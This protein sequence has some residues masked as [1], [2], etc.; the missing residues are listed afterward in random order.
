MASPRC[1]LLADACRRLSRWQ[2]P[3]VPLRRRPPSRSRR[4]P[5]RCH[6]ILWRTRSSGCY[7]APAHSRKNKESTFGCL[8]STFPWKN[9]PGL[10]TGSFVHFWFWKPSHSGHHAAR[11]VFDCVWW[12]RCWIAGW[13]CCHCCFQSP[14]GCHL[15]LCTELCVCMWHWKSCCAWNR[16]NKWASTDAG[17][18]WRASAGWLSRWCSR[19]SAAFEFSLG[20]LFD[21]I[22][23]NVNVFRKRIT[24]K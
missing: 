16:F 24:R 9:S 3:P 17:G 18:W 1:L 12:Q 5:H 10:E 8:T 7:A 21:F 20:L 6:W 22:T 4:C 11:Q 2:A 14:S 23:H 15:Q 13:G 19:H